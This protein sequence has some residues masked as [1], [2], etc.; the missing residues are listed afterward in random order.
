VAGYV[1]GGKIKFPAPLS[2]CSFAHLHEFRWD[3]L[4]GCELKRIGMALR[5]DMRSVA[6]ETG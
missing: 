6:V 5:K 1:T 2:V 4:D 3:P